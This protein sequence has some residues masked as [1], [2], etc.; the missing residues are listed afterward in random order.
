MRCR[1]SDAATRAMRTIDAEA[2]PLRDSV[3]GRV[4]L[5]RGNGPSARSLGSREVAR[6]RAA[7]VIV[8]GCNDAG[9]SVGAGMVFAVDDDAARR[10]VNDAARRDGR[11]V[12]V[13]RRHVPSGRDDVVPIIDFAAGVATGHGAAWTLA[14]LGAA[15]V[16]LA[17]FDGPIDPGTESGQ[18]AT[19]QVHRGWCDWLLGAA[20]SLPQHG[21][22][23]RL[24]GIVNNDHPLWQLPAAPTTID[25]MIAEAESP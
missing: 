17:G 13:Q 7:G 12:V 20:A 22:R 1:V 21:C 24:V 19:R 16:A 10:L 5:V 6:L 3:R 23:W 25:R 4:V 9:D 11:V 14:A 8:A 15:E 18:M 2:H